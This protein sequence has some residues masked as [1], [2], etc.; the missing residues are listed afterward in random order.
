MSYMLFVLCIELRVSVL[1]EIRGEQLEYK[2][3]FIGN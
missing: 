1:G 2:S 3:Y